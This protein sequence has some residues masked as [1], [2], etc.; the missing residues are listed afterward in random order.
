MSTAGSKGMER[1]NQLRGSGHY[2]EMG[3]FEMEET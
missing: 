3:V 2:I 1:K